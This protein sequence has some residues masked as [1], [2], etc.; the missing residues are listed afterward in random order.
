MYPG[1]YGYLVPTCVEKLSMRLKR[2]MRIEVTVR[3]AGSGG[4][5]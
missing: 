1:T 2:L 4:I 3:H 5:A